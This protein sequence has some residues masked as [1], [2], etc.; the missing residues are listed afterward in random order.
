MAKL[1]AKR[2]MA[3]LTGRG[4]GAAVG[5]AAYAL[6]EKY[7][8]INNNAIRLGVLGVAGAL[9]PELNPKMKI[10]DNAGAGFIG[11]VASDATRL[12]LNSNKVQG[13]GTQE[14]TYAIDEDDYVNGLDDDD[15]EGDELEGLDGLEDTDQPESGL[16]DTDESGFIDL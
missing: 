4:V 13:I 8:P 11:A 5:G 14:P 2:M 7:V 6:G 10:L 9:L 3:A 12:M 16:G 1:D 15:Y